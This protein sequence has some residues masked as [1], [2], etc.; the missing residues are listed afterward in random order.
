VICEKER[1]KEERKKERGQIIEK[2]TIVVGQI[3]VAGRN[4]QEDVSMFF[5]L[6]HFV[7]S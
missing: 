5:L 7:E 1:R 4:K 2:I 3:S 6:V